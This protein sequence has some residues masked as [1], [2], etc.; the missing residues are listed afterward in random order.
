MMIGY[1][2]SEGNI[3]GE[4][5]RRPKNRKVAVLAKSALGILAIA[6]ALS[7]FKAHYFIG[8]MTQTAR[9][10]DNATVFLVV[11]DDKTPVRGATMAFASRGLSPIVEDDQVIVKFMDG[12][13]GDQVNVGVRH[14]SINGTEIVGDLSAVADNLGVAPERFVRQQ[15]LGQDE[16]WMQGRTAKSFDS[17]FWGPIKT[18]QIIGRAYILF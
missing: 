2:K 5:W 1:R 8:I 10:I 11:K 12:L 13:P 17:R 15:T 7:Y 4:R 6:L 18:E 9:C 3:G 16:Y 14:T